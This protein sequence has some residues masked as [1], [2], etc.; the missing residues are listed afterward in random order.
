MSAAA[1]LLSQLFA[2][3]PAGSLAEIRVFCPSVAR[4]WGPVGDYGDV[5]KIVADVAGRGPV[6]HGLTPKARKGSCEADALGYTAIALDHDIAEV[7]VQAHDVL[8]AIGLAP[9]AIVS[10]GRGFHT[11]LFLDAVYSVESAKPIAKRLQVYLDLLGAKI[12]VPGLGGDKIWDAARVLRTPGSTNLK[13]GTLC[14]LQ[15]MAGHRYSLAHIARVLDAQNA[16]EV[17]LSRTTHRPPSTPG[18]AKERTARQSPLEGA[19]LDRGHLELLWSRLSPYE[20]HLAQT[21]VERGRRRERDWR[22]ACSLARAGATPEEIACFAQSCR[23]LAQKLVD[24]DGGGWPYWSATAENAWRQVR[25][26]APSM[27]WQTQAALGDIDIVR[28]TIW[29]AENKSGTRIVV[30]MALEDGGDIVTGCSEAFFESVVRRLVGTR[31]F[32]LMRGKEVTLSTL[33][34]PTEDGVAREVVAWYAA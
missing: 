6:Y 3:A 20:Q 16:P 26:L 32:K 18:L 27:P 22:V 5:D 7:G 34:V 11:Y 24:L 13:T 23:G 33:A 9:S 8:R 31:V 19:E 4:V 30:K 10:S 12:G 25:S 17:T 21:E 1:D 29:R 15:E 14:T 2:P 28:A